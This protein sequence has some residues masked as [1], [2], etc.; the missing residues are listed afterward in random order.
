MKENIEQFLYG[1]TDTLQNKVADYLD[2]NRKHIRICIL[3]TVICGEDCYNWDNNPFDAMEGEEYE[4]YYRFAYQYRED[5]KHIDWG[6][7]TTM[8][9]KHISGCRDFDE[10]MTEEEFEELFERKKHDVCSELW[11]EGEDE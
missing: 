6:E 5:T 11:Y 7:P 3:D 1:I 10:V 2:V 9:W 8:I 4:T